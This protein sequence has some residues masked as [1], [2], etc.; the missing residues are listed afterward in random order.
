MSA[1]PLDC[2]RDELE[3]EERKNS[4]R[5]GKKRNVIEEVRDALF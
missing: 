3:R 1:Y 2:L 5:I 4:K